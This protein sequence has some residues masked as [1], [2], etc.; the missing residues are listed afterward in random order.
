MLLRLGFGMQWFILLSCSMT[1][2]RKSIPKHFTYFIYGEHLMSYSRISTPNLDILLLV[3]CAQLSKLRQYTV[4]L[5]SCQALFFAS[6]KSFILLLLLKPCIVFLL[7]LFWSMAVYFKTHLSLAFVQRLNVFNVNSSNL[8]PISLIFRDLFIT[9]HS[10]P[11]C[12]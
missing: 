10:Y 9:I 2:S 4:K 7:D 5:K 6:C 1:Y 12:S 8:L 3:P 11:S